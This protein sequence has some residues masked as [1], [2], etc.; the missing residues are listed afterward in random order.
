MVKEYK[1]VLLGS[2]GVGKS[3]LTLRYV[4]GLFVARYNPTIEDFYRHHTRLDGEEITVEILDTAGTEQYTA[5][6][7][8]YI[9][10][11]QAFILVYAIDNKQTFQDIGPLINQITDLKKSKNFPIICVGNKCDLEEEREVGRAQ[12]ERKVKEEFRCMFS[13][14]SAKEDIGVSELFKN[15][16][17]LISE[18]QQK[19]Q[20]LRRQQSRKKSKSGSCCVML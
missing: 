19:Q 6:H 2:G 15:C 10:H 18:Y 5:M 12:A 7:Q 9:D 1:I 3:A 4:Q 13:E 16:I 8:L 17:R 14:A 20:H 11:G